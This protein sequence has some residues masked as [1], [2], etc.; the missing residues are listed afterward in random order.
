VEVDVNGNAAFPQSEVARTTDT[1][2][3]AGNPLVTSP[4]KLFY[5]DTGRRRRT[6]AFRSL[7]I[8][9]K[10]ELSGKAKQRASIELEL[11]PGWS[12]AKDNRVVNIY[13]EGEHFSAP[14]FRRHS[15]LYAPGPAAPNRDEIHLGDLRRELA[16]IL[17]INDPLSLQLEIQHRY[18]QATSSVFSR[19]G[20]CKRSSA[21]WDDVSVNDRQSLNQV[22]PSRDAWLRVR[23]ADYIKLEFKDKDMVCALTPSTNATVSQLREL[24]ASVADTTAG[25]I[26]M[27]YDDIELDDAMVALNFIDFEPGA[28]ISI[29]VETRECVNCIGDVG[30]REFPFEPTTEECFHD[31]DICKRCIETWITTCLDNGNWRNITCLS[32]DCGSVL[33]YADVKRGALPADMQRYERFA[34]HDALSGMSGF[35]WCLAPNCGSGQIH[36]DADGTEQILTCSACGFKRCTACDRAWHQDETCE[37]YTQRLAAQP[38]ENDAS[39]AWV[40]NNSR[41]CPGCKSPI[42]KNDGCDHMTC[43]VFSLIKAFYLNTNQLQKAHAAIDSSAGFALL[44]MTTSIVRVTQ[45]TPSIA[46]TVSTLSLS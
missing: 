41:R 26:H 33:Q 9:S 42:Q 3:D 37:E 18:T 40:A 5:T 25:A 14:Y 17:D 22:L 13:L 11:F 46:D 10:K 28:L 15:Y 38:T 43:K 8:L 19:R 45:P 34:T 35:K 6:P 2:T 16:R 1:K 31:L 4:T 20:V 27:Y 32:A 24:I 21:A 39:E 44:I 12:T 36:D 29:E 30:W 7:P 23:I